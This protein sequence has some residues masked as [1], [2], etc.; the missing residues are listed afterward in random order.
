MPDVKNMKVQTARSSL[1]LS[2]QTP[3]ADEVAKT[4]R[5]RRCLSEDVQSLQLEDRIAEK[6]KATPCG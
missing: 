4:A 5:E 3:I 6:L 1:D 2:A